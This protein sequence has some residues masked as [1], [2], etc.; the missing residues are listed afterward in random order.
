VASI[1]ASSQAARKKR[2]TKLDLARM[3]SPQLGNLGPSQAEREEESEAQKHSPRDLNGLP[4]SISQLATRN[5][6]TYD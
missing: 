1:L 2:F 5:M 4:R 6:L 3:L